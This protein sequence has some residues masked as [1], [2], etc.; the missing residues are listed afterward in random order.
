MKLI[1]AGSRSINNTFLI[2]HCFDQFK[3]KDEVD[4][5]VEGGAQGVD[6]NASILAQR[7]KLYLTTMCA[8]WAQYGKRAGF[9]RN[10]EMAVYAN[11]LL[12]VWNGH[13]SGTHDMIKRAVKK[14]LYVEVYDAHGQRIRVVPQRIT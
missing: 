1:I 11:A 4:E 7:R 9:V 8:D 12:A 2:G 6:H 10:E 5:I 3:Y 14:G 13:S